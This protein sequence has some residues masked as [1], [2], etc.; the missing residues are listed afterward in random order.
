[1]AAEVSNNPPAM[2]YRFCFSW[3]VRRGQHRETILVFAPMFPIY[4]HHPRACSIIQ[5][6]GLSGPRAP[7]QR[8]VGKFE[9]C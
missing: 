4:L 7:R 5:R 1:V 8:K 2:F 6:I 3:L 9:C